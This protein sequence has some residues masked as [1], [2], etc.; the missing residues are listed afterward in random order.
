MKSNVTKK[1]VTSA[2]VTALMATAKF[3]YFQLGKTLVGHMTLENGFEI[4]ES[5][6]CIDP[7]NFDFEIGK[8]IV[9][10]RLENRLWELEGYRVQSENSKAEQE[11]IKKTEL[12][13]KCLP[14]IPESKL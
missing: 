3:N 4:M 11:Y 7:A 5:S 13:R 10:K 8:E 9:E 1:S 12:L 6:A 14:V 2:D